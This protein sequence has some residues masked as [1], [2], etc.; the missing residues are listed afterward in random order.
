MIG[1]TKRVPNQCHRP[2]APGKVQFSRVRPFANG[3]FGRI[4]ILS[5]PRMVIGTRPSPDT[6]H[7]IRL[8][9]LRLGVTVNPTFGG[10]LPT[11]FES[12]GVKSVTG[13]GSVLR[14]S[15]NL[16]SPPNFSLMAKR[17]R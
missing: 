2:P 14:I 9:F 12:R 17:G 5:V 1:R 6:K 10:L 11:I 13:S 3:L 16:S 4:S 8:R 15:L 7:V